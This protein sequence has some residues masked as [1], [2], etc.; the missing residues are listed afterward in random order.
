MLPTIFKN[1]MN[2]WKGFVSRMNQ[3][4]VPLPM[5]RDPKTGRGDVAL[6][7]VFLS[8]IWVQLG[9]I[10][11]FANIFQGIDISQA[12]NWFYA[13]CALYWARKLSSDGKGKIDLG[14]S[15]EQKKDP[16]QSPPAE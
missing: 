8:S 1:I 3:I 15:S 13:C 11:K 6:T 10:G 2:D 12:L 16:S 14:E 4:G 7:L 9:L 5:V